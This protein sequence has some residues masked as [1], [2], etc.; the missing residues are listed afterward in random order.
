MRD[1]TVMEG[2]SGKTMDAEKAAR[3]LAKKPDQ[4]PAVLETLKN[5]PKAV[6]FACEKS[7]RMLSESNPGLLYQYFGE[8]A[9]LLDHENSFIQWGAILTVA[10]LARADSEE[11]FESIFTKYFKPLKGPVMVAASSVIGGSA[12]I[13]RAKPRLADRIAAE[14]LKVEKTVF[15]MHGKASPECGVIARGQA[16]DALGEMYD[17]LEKRKGVDAFILRQLESS[18]P[19]VRKRAE[20]LAKKLGLGVK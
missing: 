14:I 6:K 4:I 11:R 3:E 1:S 12:K 9:G 17:L 15:E 8:L 5:N 10:N 13:A 19:K 18:R 2:L 7:L 16:M 20:L